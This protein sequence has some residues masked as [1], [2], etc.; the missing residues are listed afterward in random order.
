[1]AAYVRDPFPGNIIPQSAWDPVAKNIVEK[2][3]IQ[4]PQFDK[5]AAITF[6]S[7]AQAA[8][9][10]MSTSIGVKID[11]QINGR[12]HISGYYNQ[13]YRNRNNSLWRWL[14]PICPFP[15]SPTSCWKEQ[16]TPGNMVRLSLTST[17]SPTLVNRLAA[18]YNRF[19][20]ENGAPPGTVNQNLGKP[21]RLAESRP[22]R[23]FP[24]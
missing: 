6:R 5:H 12:N 10:S 1:M 18:G 15:G 7:W 24:R 3:G 20:N 13:S 2:V 17:I 14:R 19:L 4:D 9:I 11:H 8:H 23:L 21:D 16:T 22:A